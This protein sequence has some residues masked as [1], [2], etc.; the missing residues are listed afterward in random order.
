MK[1]KEN[2]LRV[3]GNQMKKQAN[4]LEMKRHP[5]KLKGNQLRVNDR[6]VSVAGCGRFFYTLVYHIKKEWP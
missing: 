5:L 2:E 4:P 1:L 3:E 6:W